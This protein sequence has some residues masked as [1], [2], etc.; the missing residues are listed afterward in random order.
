M[1][2]RS[3]LV[4]WIQDL[5][6]VDAF[7]LVEESRLENASSQSSTK[8]VCYQK[9]AGGYY[10]QLIAYYIYRTVSSWY[11]QTQRENSASPTNASF[12]RQS[13]LDNEEDTT[14]EEEEATMLD[15]PTVSCLQ[16]AAQS[17]QQQEQ[18]ATKNSN[19]RQRKLRAMHARVSA[20]C[21][22]VAEETGVMSRAA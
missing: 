6:R 7:G 9:E 5:E 10:P 4:G 14:Q 12:V 21:I 16:E 13:C 8:T 1:K 20:V 19:S 15:T 17:I 11:Q 18:A 3:A 2:T 22:Y